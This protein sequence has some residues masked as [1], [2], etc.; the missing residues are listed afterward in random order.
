[1]KNP[2]QPVRVSAVAYSALKELAAESHRP[3]ARCLDD[4]VRE[5]YERRLWSRFALANRL[6]HTDPATRLADHTED[7]LWSIAD[8]DGLEPDDGVAPDDARED[9]A[10]W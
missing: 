2:G 7:A 9:A 4:I 1:M 8:L 10:S 3:I 5:A 6:A